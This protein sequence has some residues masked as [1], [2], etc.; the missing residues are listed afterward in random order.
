MRQLTSL[1]AQFLALESARQTGHVGG[2]AILDPSTA[3]GGVISAA[4]VQEVI[5]AR[6][7]LLPPLRW[8]LAEVPLGLDH[9][10]WVDDADFDLEYHVREIALP[11]PGDDDQLAEQVARICA[12][13][14]DR[15]RPLWEIYLIYGL[16]E[17]HVAM[18]T[19]IHHA[20]IDG[21]SGAEI[22]GLLL[23]L[24]PEGREVPDAHENGAGERMPGRSRD[25]R[26]RPAGVAAL[27]AA[28]TAC[29]AAR[30]AEH[31]GDTV[32]D[33]A[34]CRTP[35]TARGRRAARRAARGGRPRARESR[36]AEDHVQRSRLRAPAVRL[37]TDPAGRHQG[38]QERPWLHGE[39]RRRLDVRGCGAA[40]AGRARR[41]P[42]RAARGTDPRCR[43]APGIRQARS[44]IASC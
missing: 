12:R 27:P 30:G 20:V 31:R 24:Q 40:L 9:P 36:R 8:R 4:R 37:R 14:L 42:R 16:A 13:P 22:M 39:R 1:D 6:I 5:A 28:G 7:S 26:P 21:M 25:A 32:R 41:A 33:A 35:R 38:R 43:C 23:D 10:Y 29:P 15:A 11:P 34:R 44:A 19:K 3:P 18:L 17:G 2:L